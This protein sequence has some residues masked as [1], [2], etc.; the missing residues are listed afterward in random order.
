M[1]IA[2]ISDLHIGSDRDNPHEVNVRRLNFVID[3]LNAM[4][5][6][7]DL[8]LVTG[9][10]VEHGDDRDA[11]RHMKA[12]LGRWQ[13][14]ALFAIGNHDDRENFRK[15]M[16]AV[17]T[18]EGGFIQYEADCGDVRVIVIDT[19]ETGRHGGAFCEARAEW[20]KEKLSQRRKRPTMIAMHH[21]PVDV[22]IVWIS[23]DDHDAW[24]DRLRDVIKPASQ[25]K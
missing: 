9:D 16:P 13:A 22:G 5:P 3:R 1:L 8:L 20:L 17:M 14:P 19:V 23:P 15:A 25:V 2:Q 12:L 11:Y 21:P 6:R 24:V 10:L 7:P 18:D 4:H